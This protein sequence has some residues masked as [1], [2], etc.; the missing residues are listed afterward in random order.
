MT[1]GGGLEKA[2][3]NNDSLYTGTKFYILNN[4]VIPNGA[5]LKLESNEFQFNSDSYKMYIISDS[6]SGNIDII[7]KQ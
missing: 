3:T 5:S 7:T 6:S 1:F 2:L 4:V